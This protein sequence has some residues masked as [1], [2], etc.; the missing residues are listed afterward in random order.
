M[1]Q[2]LLI[3]LCFMLFGCY[4]N[5]PYAP[6]RNLTYEPPSASGT[7]QVKRGDTLYSIAWMYGLD[8]R[9]LAKIN[10]LPAD[11]TIHPGQDLRLN[12]PTTIAESANVLYDFD[13]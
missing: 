5:G 1:R 11:Y 13:S 8:Y 4:T 12:Q 7:Y 6:V 2:W 10:K 3:I 9:Y